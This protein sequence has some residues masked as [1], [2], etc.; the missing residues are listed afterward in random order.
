MVQDAETYRVK[1]RAFASQG[2][3]T[4]RTK[5]RTRELREHT[6]R[7]WTIRDTLTILGGILNCYHSL[8]DHCLKKSNQRSRKK[9]VEKGVCGLRNILWFV[10]WAFV[11]RSSLCFLFLSFST[12]IMQNCEKLTVEAFTFWPLRGI[13]VWT[14]NVWKKSFRG[15][16][17]FVLYHNLPH[18][19]G[20]HVVLWGHSSSLQFDPSTATSGPS[21]WTGQ[22]T[23]QGCPLAPY[24]LKLWMTAGANAVKSTQQSNNIFT[25][26]YMDDRTFVSPTF[27][28]ALEQKR[29]WEQWSHLAALQ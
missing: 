27:D 26:V 2:A 7:S 6:I 12:N 4:C 18:I 13:G 20:K 19:H 21:A 1:K 15:P 9:H 16:S 22:A 8:N 24:I 28:E 3:W 5:K 23:P 14:S 17:T 11:H 29:Q 25:R 10:H